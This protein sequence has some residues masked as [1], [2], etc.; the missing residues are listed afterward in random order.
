MKR[1]I[2]TFIILIGV[3]T[4]L[5]N[6]I[7][8]FPDRIMWILN[9]NLFFKVFFP[10]LMSISAFVAIFKIEKHAYFNLASG[11]MMIDA[12]YRL[13]IVVNHFYGYLQYKDISPAPTVPGTVRVVTNLWPSHIM[14]FIEIIFIMMIFRLFMSMKQ[15]IVEISS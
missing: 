11:A 7:F 10:L 14:L 3:Y 8:S 15:S 12:I 4:L 1:L 9:H 2:L 6:N 13:S 5:R